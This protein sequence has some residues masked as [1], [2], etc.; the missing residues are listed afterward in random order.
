MR[1]EVKTLADCGLRASPFCP[2]HRVVDT[3]RYLDVDPASFQLDANST[4][5]ARQVADAGFLGSLHWGGMRQYEY[6]VETLA[7]ADKWSTKKQAQELAALT[8]KLNEKGS[9]GWELMG[10]HSF[11]LVGGITGSSK[12]NVTL[13]LWKREVGQAT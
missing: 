9:Q 8:A 13:T 7:L 4:G 6:H 11:D 10:L 3:S 5:R 12:G 2:W 1:A